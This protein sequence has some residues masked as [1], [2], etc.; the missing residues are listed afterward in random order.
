VASEKVQAT[1]GADSPSWLSNLT[2]DLKFALPHDLVGQLAGRLGLASATGRAGSLL[3]FDAN[4][5]H[6]SPNNVSPFSRMVAL[7]TYNSV[8]N[9]P[10]PVPNPRPEFLASRDAT[11][12]TPLETAA[13]APRSAAVHGR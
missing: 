4:V 7:V 10:R 1:Y 8:H 11:P 5:V 13:S 2:A 9:V 6:A 12:L 3:V